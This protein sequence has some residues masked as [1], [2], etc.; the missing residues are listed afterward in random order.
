MVQYITYRI[1]KIDIQFNAQNIWP[2]QKMSNFNAN[3]LGLHQL[4]ICLLQNFIH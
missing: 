3:L 4:K 2:K 1:L